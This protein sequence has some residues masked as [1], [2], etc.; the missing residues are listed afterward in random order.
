M[1][2]LCLGIDIGGANTKAVL[3]R[4]DT[5]EDEWLKYI[6]LWEGMEELY[7]F[8]ENL[9]QSV[10][11]HSVGITMTAELCDVF[12]SKR[13][14]V[15]QII[16][17]VSEIFHDKKIYF[18]SKNGDLLPPTEAS[19]SPT[20][21]SASNWV[22]S[23]LLVGKK[24]PD[25]LLIDIGSTTT[26]I[27]P[28]KNGKPAPQ[29]WT[30]FERLQTNEL[31]YTGLLR[32]PPPYLKSIIN[33]NDMEINIASEYF[34]NM[35]DV[36]RVLEIL[37]EEEYTC[38]TPDGRGKDKKNCMKRIARLVCSDLEEVGKTRV[39]KIAKKFHQAQI[40]KLTKAIKKLKDLHDIKNQT[41]TILTG[42][43]G[44][45]IGKKA[46]EKSNQEEIIPLS[47]IYG[48]TAEVMTPAFALGLITSEETCS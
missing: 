9:Q 6:P 17:K 19:N 25:F 48:E 32:T 35:A 1:K 2:M 24:Y 40:E 42:I 41:P 14:G 18:L 34:A 45:K 23:A 47:K 30:D 37:K 15:K 4:D 13:K 5:V 21:L 8:F 38:K 7:N 3:F 20:E 26:D 29:G 33:L 36:Y 12:E 16:E 10:Q 27:I 31:I 28:V 46:A 11:P 22:A 43:G 44:K 39:K